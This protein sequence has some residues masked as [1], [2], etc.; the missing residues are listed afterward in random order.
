[1]YYCAGLMEQLWEQNSDKEQN[2]ENNLYH[3]L[4]KPLC[5]MGILWI[6]KGA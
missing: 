6:A 5:Y 2:T 4:Y 3:V 1:M